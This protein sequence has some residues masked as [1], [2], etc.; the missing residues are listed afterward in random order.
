MK[1]L[2]AICGMALFLVSCEKTTVLEEYDRVGN[3][4][5]AQS[6]SSLPAEVLTE[7]QSIDM[8][9]CKPKRRQIGQEGFG[10]TAS[11]NNSEA[12]GLSMIY[13]IESNSK[14]T[15][16]MIIELNFPE[17]GT[18]VSRVP[19]AAERLLNSSLQGEWDYTIEGNTM[20]WQQGEKMLI[21]ELQ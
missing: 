14:I 11:I 13:F 1:K 3:I 4:W 2:I 18:L 5:A 9:R 10:C 19:P 20:T 6:T 21:F 16:S 12:Q 17:E 7:I 8:T 15:V